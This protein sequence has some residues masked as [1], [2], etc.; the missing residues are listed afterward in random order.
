MKVK[1]RFSKL[2][3]SNKIILIL[4]LAIALVSWILVGV[5]VDDRMTTVIS[6]VPVKIDTTDTTPEKY[7]LSVIEGGIQNITV[8]V[9]GVR[10]E[11]GNL[12]EDDIVVTPQLNSITTSG[13]QQV[14]IVVKITKTGDFR[15]VDVPE[16]VDVTFDRLDSKELEI[17]AAADKIKASEGFRKDVVTASPKTIQLTGPKAE[18]DLIAQVR[19]AYDVDDTVDT[20]IITDEVKLQLLDEFGNVLQQGQ[21]PHVTLPDTT[22]TLTVPIYMTKTLPVNVEFMNNTGKLDTSKL[23]YKLSEVNLLVAGPKDIVQ[24]KQEITIGPV[25][26]SKLDLDSTHTF[27]VTLEA[28]LINEEEIQQITVTLADAGYDSTV[29]HVDGG[30]N[31]NILLQNTPA[32]MNVEILTTQIKNVKLVGASADITDLSAEELIARV[33]LSNLEEGTSRVRAKIYVT[34]SSALYEDSNKYVWAVGE[35]YVQVKAERK[36]TESTGE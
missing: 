6:N 9:E 19:L 31:G 8:K 27:P 18:L 17:V 10:A 2:L 26:F 16:S 29:L 28:G 3:E 30:E 34:G 24:S 21:I 14:P 25:D 4:S 33:D 12:T 5:Y 20:T 32:D 23:R 7:G 36:T 35:Y 1:F 11:V 15:I 13:K 22:Y